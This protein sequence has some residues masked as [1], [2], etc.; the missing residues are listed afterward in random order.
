MRNKRRQFTA[1]LLA[2]LTLLTAVPLG[3]IAASESGY[4]RVDNSGFPQTSASLLTNLNLADDASAELVE[5][6]VRVAPGADVA[7]G[8]TL[9]VRDATGAIVESVQLVVMGDVTGTGRASLSQLARLAQALGGRELLEGPYAQAADLSGNGPIDL[10]DL[11]RLAQ[12][13]KDVAQYDSPRMTQV[14]YPFYITSTEI[15]ND[16]PM[17]FA[18]GRMDV[19]YLSI[20]DACDLVGTLLTLVDIPAIEGSADGTTVTWTNVGNGTTVVFDFAENTI[21]FDDYNAF[22]M[23]TFA[24]TRLDIVTESG[25]AEDGSVRY[26]SRPEGSFERRGHGVLVDL[27]NYAIEM[28]YEN[29]QGYIP[30][31]TVSDLFTSR[32]TLPIVFNGEFTAAIAGKSLG[33]LEDMYYSVPQRQRSRA[34]RDF[35]YNELCMALDLMYGL[36]DQHNI[37]GFQTYFEETG[38]DQRLKSADP[39]T[40]DK[41][42]RELCEGF[43]GDLHSQF[44]QPSSYAGKDADTFTDHMSSSWTNFTSER[45]KLVAARER[46]YPDG[47]PGYEEIGSTAFVH[48]DSFRMPEED[49]D[50]YANPP[51]TL[52]EAQDTVGLIMYAHSQ[53]MREDSP[54]ENVIVDLATNTGGE[55]NA[56]V[57]VISWMLGKATISLDDTLTGDQAQT[58]YR[59]D[60]N[61]DGVCDQKDTI[62]SKN[63]YCLVSPT[64]FSCGNLVPAALKESHQVTLVGK[65]TAGGACVVQ[66][67]TV[68][69]GTIFQISGHFRLASLSNGSYYDIDRGV[70]PD[71]PLTHVD[72]FF[73]RERL[74]TYLAGYAR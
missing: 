65:N 32:L 10:A 46:A 9:I 57:F 69:D 70:V 47:V 60:V 34:L 66:Y 1:A 26:L 12:Q 74:A 18:D 23:Q 17:Y 8:Q 13:V 5:D 4:Y 48:F 67:M 38:L 16:Q 68:A 39:V 11:V 59:A 58:E 40:A 64:S 44:G 51:K 28:I 27:D 24:S 71:I 2:F 37:S 72:S 53:I 33:D 54:I 25:I 15:M 14:S 45:E 7:T 35:S 20:D 50:Y 19:P 63:L 52:E 31:Q 61:G 36:K 41:A 42:V 55:A 6:G 21:W 3:T 56:A 30:L 49:V 43:F 22:L 62:A 73:D 29:N